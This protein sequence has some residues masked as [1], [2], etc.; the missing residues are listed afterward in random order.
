M[1]CLAFPKKS[2]LRSGDNLTCIESNIIVLGNEYGS[3]SFIQSSAVHVDSCSDRENKPTDCL[4]DARLL[5]NTLQRN[6][7]GGR[8]G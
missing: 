4:M 1:K 7:K 6:G 3:N 8:A 2:Y 5:L